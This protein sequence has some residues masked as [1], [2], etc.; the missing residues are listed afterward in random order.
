LIVNV[1]SSSEAFAA[2]PL[3]S[4]IAAALVRI[5]TTACGRFTTRP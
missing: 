1:L 2:G 5:Q 4:A 3:M